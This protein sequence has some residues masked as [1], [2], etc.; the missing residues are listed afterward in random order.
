MSGSAANRHF[1]VLGWPCW[2]NICIKHHPAYV[3]ACLTFLLLLRTPCLEH[4]PKIQH[5]D[6]PPC[7]T[8]PRCW[9]KPA[10]PPSHF[11]CVALSDKE[12]TSR[13]CSLLSLLDPFQLSVGMTTLMRQPSH[14]PWRRS[15]EAGRKHRSS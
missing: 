8:L 1:V 5:T 3:P 4:W 7:R 15:A 9:R 12:H 6:S 2:A 11:P 13:N 14:G 10:L